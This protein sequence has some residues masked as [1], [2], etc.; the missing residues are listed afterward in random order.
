MA[1]NAFND[2]NIIWSPLGDRHGN[3]RAAHFQLAQIT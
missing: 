1:A 2:S 3:I